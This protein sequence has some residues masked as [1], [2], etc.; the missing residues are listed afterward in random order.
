MTEA[1][2]VEYVNMGKP[3]KFITLEKHRADEYAAQWKGII[4][5]LTKMIEACPPSNSNVSLPLSMTAGVVC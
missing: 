3:A 2:L 1:Y 5:P 4:Y